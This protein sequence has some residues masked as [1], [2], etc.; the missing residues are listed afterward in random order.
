MFSPPIMG[1]RHKNFEDLML[2]RQDIMEIKMYNCEF[3]KRAQSCFCLFKSSWVKQ[4]QL[5][6]LLQDHLGQYCYTYTHMLKLKYVHSNLR[7]ASIDWYVTFSCR[8]INF[9]H[10]HWGKVILFSNFSCYRSHPK[11]MERVPSKD[12]NSV[13]TSPKQEGPAKFICNFIW[14]WI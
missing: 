10:G 6:S 2:R 11:T 5:G 7:N 12:V 14:T 4:E 3:D 8:L 1:G 13:A 9:R